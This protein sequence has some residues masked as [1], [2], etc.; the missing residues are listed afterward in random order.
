M[1][2]VQNGWHALVLA[3]LGDEQI[4]RAVLLLGDGMYYNAAFGSDSASPQRAAAITADRA[5]LERALQ[6]LQGGSSLNPQSH[7]IQRLKPQAKTAALTPYFLQR[8]RAP[9]LK[10]EGYVSTLQ[11]RS[12]DDFHCC[13]VPVKP[14]YADQW[15]EKTR[16][17]TEATRAEEGNKFFEWSRSIED[18]NEFVLLSRLSTT[19]QLARHVNS[20]LLPAGF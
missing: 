4:A 18:P 17:F 2:R 15:I 16:A 19:T 12:S 7:P 8:R 13:K 11:P 6:V 3:E 20:G 9:G 1:S 14:E 5:A 10:L